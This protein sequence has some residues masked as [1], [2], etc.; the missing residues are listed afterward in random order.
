M[1][2]KEIFDIIWKNDHKIKKGIELISDFLG[3][4]RQEAER[5]YYD[6]YIEY[7][8]QRDRL[9]SGNTAEKTCQFYKSDKVCSALRRMYCMEEVCSFYKKRGN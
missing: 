6:E 8:R 1:S 3:I 2:K 7:K 4:S 9:A 5:I